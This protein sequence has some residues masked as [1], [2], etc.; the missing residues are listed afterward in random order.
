M[1]FREM[2]GLCGLDMSTPLHWLELPH[3]KNSARAGERWLA[4][5]A[6]LKDFLAGLSGRKPTR[7][8]LLDSLTTFQQARQTFSRL[9]EARRAGRVPAVWFFLIANSFFLDRIE[10]WTAALDAAL[11]TFQTQAKAAGLVFLAGSPIYFPNFKL[12]HLLEVAGLTVTGDDL[13]SSER[14]L[15][16]Q[17]TMDDPTDF[18]LLRALAES[19][20]QG[21]LCPTFGD[22]GRRLNNI[23]GAVLGTTIKGVILHVLK[24]C[25]PYDLESLT[26]EEPLKRAGLKF[27]RLE[28]DYAAEDGRNLL[29]RLEAFGNN[30]ENL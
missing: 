23:R 30:L 11:P 25:H 20:H 8:M 12:L 24:G 22:N 17:V 3:L 4:E 9:I 18:G 21:C 7:K 16:A 26:L 10:R 2:M 29:T 6:G 5:V 19:Y 13:C 15:P 27:I 14:L 28:T 1:K